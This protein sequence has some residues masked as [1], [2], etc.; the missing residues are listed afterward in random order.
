[1]EYVRRMDVN[2]VRGDGMTDTLSLII[3]KLDD[4]DDK[5]EELPVIQQKVEQLSIDIKELKENKEQ[6]SVK[7]QHYEDVISG[8]NEKMTYKSEQ[9]HLKITYLIGI[10]SS[11]ILAIN[12]IIQLI[13]R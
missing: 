10:L 6:T 4:M 7:M 13:G 3:K 2:A 8:I 5:L 1:M 12:I 11:V 9:S